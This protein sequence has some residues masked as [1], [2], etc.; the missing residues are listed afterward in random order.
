MTDERIIGM[1]NGLSLADKIID[2]LSEWA[3]EEVN[4]LSF[5]F[6][7]IEIVMEE[8]TSDRN[9]FIINLKVT[10]ISLAKP[11]TLVGGKCHYCSN[12]EY[13]DILGS[14]EVECTRCGRANNRK[15]VIG[16]D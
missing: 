16:I 10:D 8:T 13:Y 9:V 15:D 6:E 14:D 7:G 5:D 3:N 12:G 11:R 2:A 1:F 4:N